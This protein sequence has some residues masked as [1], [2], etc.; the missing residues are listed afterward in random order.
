V[1]EKILYINASN[2]KEEVLGANKPVVV[3]FYSTECPPC[4]AL[5]AKYESL[6]EIYGDD[7]KF[8]K[9]FRQENKP[10]A[11]SLGVSSSPTVLFFHR[12]DRVGRTYSGGIR[13]AELERSLHALLDPKR[14]AL[15]KQREKKVV[16][17]C[18]VAIIGGGPAGVTA[19]IYTAQAKL[20]TIVI[21]KGMSGGN[22][23]V[24]HQVSNYP[25]FIEPQ[26]GYM[27]A[28]YMAEQART[29]GAK[30]REAS[31]ITAIDLQKKE[32]VLDGVETIRAKKIIV[33]TG[34]EPRPLGIAGESEYK[35]KGV[36]YCAT[37][38]AK[39]YEGKHVVIIG[40]GN[41][42]IEEALFIDKFT[43]KITVVHQFDKLQANKTAQERALANPKIEFLFEHEPR[44]FVPGPM[45]T[46]NRV[47]M[48]DLKTHELKPIDCD[49]V[50]VFAGMRPN[51]DLFKDALELDQWGYV[52]VDEDM[53]TKVRDVFAVGDI[54]H[55]KYR[56]ITTAVSDGTIAAM[57]AAK[58]LGG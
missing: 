51:L 36:S 33:A 2:W 57:A 52:L 58:E 53:H 31:D 21:D 13:R 25:G 48:E 23:K 49:G 1:S 16:T 38:D 34:S 45:G 19:A 3:D 39:Y 41:T 9:I 55:K 42:A 56:Q 47:I 8:V 11:E 43:K 40:G 4:E 30:F 28:H 35:G 20:D 17:E 44:E 32:I 7:L 6:A 27:L 22:V 5:A 14:A 50:F 18:D 12:G 26:S 46:V 54:V 15:L 24:T 37:C 10:L 29:A